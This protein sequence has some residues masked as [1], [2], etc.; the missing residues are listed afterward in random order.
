ML[1]KHRE[2]NKAANYIREANVRTGLTLRCER[3]EA[4]AV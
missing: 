1:C 3:Y 4:Q 2:P